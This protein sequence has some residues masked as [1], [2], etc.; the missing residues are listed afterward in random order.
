MIRF[1]IL[2]IERNAAGS[3]RGPKYFSWRFD[4]DPPGIACLWSLKDYGSIDMG[5]L[6]ADILQAD[7]DALILNTD[8]YAFPENLDVLMALADRSAFN[9]FAEAHGIPADWLSPAT[10][11]RECLKITTGMMLFNQ[12]VCAI[13]GYPNNPYTGI[14]LNTQYRNIPNPL[15]DAI[16]QASD[17]FGYTW[18]ISDNDQLRKILK[19]MSNKW[20]SQIIYFGFVEI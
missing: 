5:V 1:Y 16:R 13:L 18:D 6:A 19:N 2:P 12:K 9:N 15:H 7:H 3:A 17:L 8:V 11:F 14:T 4:P 10:T 20:I